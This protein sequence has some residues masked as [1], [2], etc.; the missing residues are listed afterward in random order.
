MKKILTIDD[1]EINLEVIKGIFEKYLSEYKCITAL[2]GTEGLEIANKELPDVI[3]LDVRMPNMDGYEV[4]KKLKS[5]EKTKHIPI[6]FLTAYDTMSDDMV[7]GLEAGADIFL[8]KPFIIN[9]FLAQ[10][11]VLLRIKNAEDKLR[12]EKNNLEEKVKDRTEVLTKFNTTLKQEIETRKKTEIK[13]KNSE[14]RYKEL[15]DNSLA[16]IFRT[17]L[18]NSKIIEINQKAADTIDLTK[19]QI[20]NQSL[21]KF[22]YNFED[23]AIM[24]K[25]LKE[26]GELTDYRVRLKKADN[27]IIWISM[28][29]KA[30]PKHRYLEGTFIDVTKQV[31]AE[32]EL[33]I[34]KNEL[35]KIV[36]LRTQQ[37]IESEEKFRVFFEQ[38]AV[39]VAIID[40]KT[41]KY[42]NFNQKF[43]EICGYTRNEFK[44]LSYTSITHPNDKAKSLK[45]F[46]YL[47]NGKMT[48]FSIDKRYIKKNKKI[49]WVNITASLILSNVNKKT[50]KYVIAIIKDIT[51]NK[52]IEEILKNALIKEQEVNE[53]KTKFV[54]M[55]SHEFRTP[56]SAINFA[57]GFLKKYSNKLDEKTKEKK[58]IKI[59]KQVMHMTSLLDDIL[60][61][62]KLDANQIKYKPEYL[63]FSKFISS[64]IEE[65]EN[66]THRTHKIKI[67]NNCKKNKIFI[68]E[69]LGR[70]I[71]TNL[72]SNAIKF[73][74]DKNYIELYC[75][76]DNEKWIFKITDFGIGIKKQDLEKIFESFTRGSNIETIQ[77]TGL[78]LAIVKESIDLM[79]GKISVKSEVGKGT[80][81]TVSLP[82]N[83]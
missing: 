47:I 27:S 35:E 34:Y 61:I 71:F 10:V 15:F 16:G 19:D 9:K 73:S 45:H 37:L 58:L 56:L 33:H 1:E 59:E 50:N 69:K 12:K 46:D 70:K 7:K 21:E 66:S 14:K 74:P 31:E 75:D 63:D 79:N 22:Y 78:G 6:M 8:Q 52:Q 51:I 81:F 2:S 40:A 83:N 41:Q 60:T 62:G 3:I 32:K 36:E 49:I 28:N 20:I 25:K 5:N 48:E 42:I 24:L 67:F 26:K 80:T 18:H 17:S 44:K 4:C 64:I 77:G 53:L 65:V 29:I 43:H 57:A 72:F 13:L 54:S 11:K 68:D 82:I 38:A 55:A 23:R 76:C 39:G 30:Y